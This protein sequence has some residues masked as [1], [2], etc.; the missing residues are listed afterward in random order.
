M[1][2]PLIPQ[3]GDDIREWRR[4][5]GNISRRRLS[6]ELGIGYR[7]LW[8][9][10]DGTRPIPPLLPWALAGIFKP[11]RSRLRLEVRRKRY[12]VKRR[13]RR[14]VVS[15]YRET[16]HEKRRLVHAN[17]AALGRIVN[18]DGVPTPDERAGLE[19]VRHRFDELEKVPL[20]RRRKRR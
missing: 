2:K 8:G 14:R 17:L 3:T 1:A 6:R 16:Q 4:Q 20:P 18:R 19:A 7:S 11:L 5:C 9:Y 15:R 10:E 13:R 12:N